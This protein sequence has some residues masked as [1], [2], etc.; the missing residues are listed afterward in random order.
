ML[1]ASALILSIGFSKRS[2]L[3]CWLWTIHGSFLIGRKC[4]KVHL[5]RVICRYSNSKFSGVFLHYSTASAKVTSF[6]QETIQ[7]ENCKS[8]KQ[9]KNGLNFS[10]KVSIENYLFYDPSIISPLLWRKLPQ[11]YCAYLVKVLVVISWNEILW[12]D[13][14]L[15]VDKGDTAANRSEERNSIQILQ[16]WQQAASWTLGVNLLLSSKSS[17]FCLPSVETASLFG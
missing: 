8:K 2:M 15:K 6:Y 9:K 4:R 12:L 11:C 5:L 3:T 17:S 13:V 1:I 14:E 7:K 16:Y 10:D